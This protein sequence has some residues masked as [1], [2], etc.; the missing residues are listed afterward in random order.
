MTLPETCKIENKGSNDGYGN[1]TYSQ[2]ISVK[3]QYHEESERDDEGSIIITEAWVI[4]PK[5]TPITFDSRITLPSGSQLP[6]KKIK[7]IMNYITQTIEGIK[8]EF[9][10]GS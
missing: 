1:I 9:K 8:V 4:L 10:G 2:A 6:I 5:N 7:N 3:C